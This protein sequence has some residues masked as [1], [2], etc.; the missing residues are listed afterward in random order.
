MLQRMGTIH[1][2]DR[3]IYTYGGFG[4]VTG[5]HNDIFLARVP[6][7]SALILDE[8]ESWNRNAFTPERLY[9]PQD[10]QKAMEAGQGSI[11]Y[12]PFYEKFL[13]FKLGECSP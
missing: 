11:V 7:A 5:G 1:A 8:Y 10:C 13:Y 9:G 3:Y 4:N 2:P 6:S 12:S